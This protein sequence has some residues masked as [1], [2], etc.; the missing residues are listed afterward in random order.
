MIHIYIHGGLKKE[1]ELVEKA[2]WFALYKLM[3]RKKILDVDIWIKNITDENLALYYPGHDQY[4]HFIEIQKKQNEDG[5]L[6]AIFH[7]MVHVR[8]QER[9]QRKE[10]E[11]N[12]SY[13]KRPNEIEAF[14]LEKVLLK[15]WK[16]AHH[17]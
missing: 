5:L 16:E 10:D 8:Q 9:G 1:R 13:F 17:E 4:E 3:P 15:E 7:E 14:K 6:T 2:F 12:I 11:D